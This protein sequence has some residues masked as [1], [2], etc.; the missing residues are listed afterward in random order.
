VSTPTSITGREAAALFVAWCERRGGSVSLDEDGQLRVTVNW[1]DYPIG[2]M[3]A[4]KFGTII[5]AL[6]DDIRAL[7]ELQRVTH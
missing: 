5:D 4:E 3:T 2:N 7:L 6:A 1:R